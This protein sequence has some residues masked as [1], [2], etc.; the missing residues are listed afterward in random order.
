MKRN[1]S[2]VDGGSWLLEKN[3]KIGD[4][5]EDCVDAIIRG[6]LL[7]SIIGNRQWLNRALN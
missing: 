7:G 5:V 6:G 1:K 3:A 2:R 4:I